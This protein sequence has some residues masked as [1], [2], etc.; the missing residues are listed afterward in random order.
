MMPFEGAALGVR[1]NVRMFALRGESV[2]ACCVDGF[3][4]RQSK[5]SIARRDPL[6]VKVHDITAGAADFSV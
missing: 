5:N 6:V 2:R 3:R 4:S 1:W